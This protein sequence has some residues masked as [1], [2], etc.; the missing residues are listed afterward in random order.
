MISIEGGKIIK[1]F[2]G[3]SLTKKKDDYQFSSVVQIKRRIS[4]G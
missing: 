1:K 3:F 2:K 4:S